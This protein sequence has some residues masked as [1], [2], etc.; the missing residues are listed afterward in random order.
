MFLSNNLQWVSIYNIA[1]TEELFMW[2][3]GQRMCQCNFK[4]CIY[5]HEHSP[6][7]KANNDC[8]WDQRHHLNEKAKVS[9]SVKVNSL[10]GLNDKFAHRS[11]GVDGSNLK[12]IGHHKPWNVKPYLVHALRSLTPPYPPTN[13]SFFPFSGSSPPPGGAS[14]VS[15]I[16]KFSGYTFYEMRFKVIVNSTNPNSFILIPPTQSTFVKSSV[17]TPQF[18]S[19]APCSPCYVFIECSSKQNDSWDTIP[20]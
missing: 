1:P 5:S 13:S 19:W 14:K 18:R 8:Q 9:F 10:T 2:S 12:K 15:N 3:L 17:A 7:S 16:C 11:H 20:N 6:H 4:T